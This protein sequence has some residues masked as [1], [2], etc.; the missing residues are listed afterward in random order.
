MSNNDKE[1]TNGDISFLAETMAED[2]HVIA[3]ETKHL[4]VEARSSLTIL[5]C[6][7]LLMSLISIFLSTWLA[8]TITNTP[9]TFG[10]IVS[11]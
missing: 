6:C 4:M 10:S 8:K 3:S 7:I 9:S 11:H 1:N 2:T 5:L